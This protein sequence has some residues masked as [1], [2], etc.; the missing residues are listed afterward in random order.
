VVQAGAGA[1]VVVE[2]LL[3]RGIGAP[4]PG[5]AT[6]VAAAAPARRWAFAAGSVPGTSALV[7]AVNTGSAPVT[8][9]LLAYT[10]GDTASPP[11]APAAAVAPG[12]RAVFDLDAWG[13]TDRQVIV[14]RA[15]GPIVAGREIELGG[16]SLAIGIPFRD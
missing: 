12:G 6:A 14:V 13:I 7:A 11:S 8:I 9:E 2:E 3:A 10:P 15:N 5:S 4:A 16:V 1:R